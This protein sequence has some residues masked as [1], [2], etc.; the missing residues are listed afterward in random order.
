MIA[1]TPGDI[2]LHPVALVALVVLIVNDHYLKAAAQGTI[3]GKLSD[4]AG[5]VVFPLLVLSAVEVVRRRGA[6]SAGV[7]VIVVVTGVVFAVVKVSPGAAHLYSQALGVLAWPLRSIAG[8]TPGAD[9]SPITVLADP[10]DLLA[11]PA[12]LI[13][14]AVAIARC[15][16]TAVATGDV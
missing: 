9:V 8:G 12:L 13:A 6:S 11:L 5:L 16:A 2:L 3:T 4:I 10:S 7:L 1:R 14:Y 15:P